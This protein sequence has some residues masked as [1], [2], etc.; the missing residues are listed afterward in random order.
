MTLFFPRPARSL[1]GQ[2]HKPAPL[3]HRLLLTVYG[4]VFLSLPSLGGEIL[5]GR[6]YTVPKQIYANQAFEIHFELEVSFGS[7][8]EDLRISDFPNNPD[9]ITVGRLETTSRNRIT[10]GAQAIDVLHFTASAR[11]HKPLTH[12]FNPTLQCMFVERRT[13]GFFSHWQSYPKQHTLDPFTLRV[14]PLPEAGRPAHF[15]GAIGT[16]HLSGGLSKTSAHPGDIITLRLEL[17]GQGWL[18][19]A[20]VPA[21]PDSSLFKTYP[22]KEVLREPLRIQTEQV[23]I[24]SCTNATEL[25]AARF[26]FFNPATGRYEESVAGPFKITYT[27]TPDTPRP[28]EVRVI[29]TS[30]PAAEGNLPQTVTLERVNLSLQHA[31]PLLAVCTAALS[32]FFIFFVLYGRHTRLALLLGSV[33]LVAGGGIGYALSGK[34][35][36]ATRAI[37]RHT[38][39]LFAPSRAAA[40]LFVLNPG[41]PV[42]P[43]ENAS[44]WVRIDAAG[45]RGWIPAAALTLPQSKKD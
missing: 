2:T 38:E 20:I 21:P 8:V 10:R 4:L 23:F 36:A 26:C 35:V 37:S 5:S 45:R 33:L 24:P 42:I 1:H 13:S 29:S 14:L 41:T 6:L 32:A 3:P 27:D 7:E 11:C 39:V 12:T 30:D 17:T 15:S 44:S 25:A 18:A 22:Q 19:N 31:V 28:D 43:L 40:I 9:L 34:T 16:F